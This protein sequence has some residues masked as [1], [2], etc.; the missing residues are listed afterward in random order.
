MN[1]VLAHC[2]EALTARQAFVASVKEEQDALI[3][4]L[5]TL[6]VLLPGVSHLIVDEKGK[7]KR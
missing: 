5:K 6:Q 3:E 4:F 1:A 7:K 2:G